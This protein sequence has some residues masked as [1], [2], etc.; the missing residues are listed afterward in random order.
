MSVMWNAIEGT[1]INKKWFLLSRKLPTSLD[2][3]GL[4]S[5][6]LCSHLNAIL[7][8]HEL[9][10]PHFQQNLKENC[11]FILHWLLWVVSNHLLPF[12]S[13][14]LYLHGKYRKPCLPGITLSLYSY[15]KTSTEQHK[16][17][18]FVAPR[19]LDISWACGCLSNSSFVVMVTTLCFRG[20]T[21]EL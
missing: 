14:I 7:W 17:I 1:K 15:S 8:R 11:R 6:A 19:I 16:V 2:W 5:L 4:S 20:K 10:F 18:G 3:N 12:W 21:N 9:S 13:T